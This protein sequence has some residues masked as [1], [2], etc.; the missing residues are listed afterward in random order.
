[1][2]GTRL[3]QLALDLRTQPMTTTVLL[4]FGGT[5][6]A[7]GVPWG[8]RF[9][10]G[11]QAAGGA[12]DTAAFDRAFRA[13]DEALAR[14]SDISR[15]GFRAMIHAQTT[16]LSGLLPGEP[17]LRPVADR[18]Y[19]EAVLAVRRNRAVLDQLRDGACRLALVSNFTG[20][21]RCC[22]NELELSDYFDAVI[23]SA[24]VGWS[25]PD[26]RIFLAAL[27]SLGSA[28]DQSW[29]VGDHPD[30]DIR[31]AVALGSSS[32]WLAPRGR[33]APSGVFPTARINSLAALPRVI[34][35]RARAHSRGR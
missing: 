30:N 23:D 13:S 17:D 27:E 32:V 1:M 31:P 8:A 26:C 22:I 34:R 33:R 18:F 15:L 25:K 2:Q 16:L 20:N 12:L 7:D 4:D 21:L 29:I 3:A 35:H 6:D 9:Y 19:R 24:V 28:A 11:Y 10:A 14:H 5:L